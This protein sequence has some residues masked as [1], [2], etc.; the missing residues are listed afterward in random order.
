MNGFVDET[1]IVVSSGSGGDGA[2]SFRR[3][4]Y[5]PR[6]GPDGGDGGKGGDVVFAVRQ[7]LKTLSHLKLRRNYKAG[8]GGRGMGQRMHGK[9]GGDVVVPVP[10]GTVLRD[11]G[12]GAPVA[13]LTRD[14][15][16]F[17][18]LR[19]GRGGKG[20]SHYATSI[21]QA[22]RYAQKGIE[23]E[24]RELS[25]E[26]HLIADIG[27]VGMPNAGKSTLLSVLTNAHPLIA[28]YPFTTR[29][30]NLGLLRLPERD[31][32]LADIPG[33][34]EGASHGR[35]LGLK[36]LRHVERCA[37]LLFLV[38]LSSPDCP[39]TVRLLEA[40]L[41]TYSRSLASRPRLVVGTKL[42]LPESTAGHAAL[43][44][45]FPGEGFVA[46]SSFSREGLAPLVAA[47]RALASAGAAA[48]S[49]D[50]PA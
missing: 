7:N 30:P 27:L 47:V 21:N 44:D 10:P 34:I 2:V 17:L 36:F 38:D 31:I 29:T 15:E 39:G 32:I 1:T 22:P 11:P 45:A 46:V 18:Y 25:A 6:G 13:D 50:S 28:D 35:G 5:V 24:T 43:S 42:D 3:E 49:G 41:E 40:E 12:T 14:G 23:G 48:A 26:L 8:D 16:S 37:A 19:G 4:K 9:D 33:I 20:N